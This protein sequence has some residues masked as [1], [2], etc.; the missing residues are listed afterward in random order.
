MLLLVVLMI[1]Y[2]AG[3]YVAGR[4]ARFNGPRQ[5]VA[6]W[7][8]G[9]A[10]TVVLAVAGAL[11]GAEYNVLSQLN[12]PRIPVDEGSLATG[13]LIAGRAVSAGQL[14]GNLAGHP[15]IDRFVTDRTGLTGRYDF[16]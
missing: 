5:G 13:G 3:G 16:R 10:V 8:I 2:Y 14:A 6:V 9:L 11:L 1:A 15:A 12:L 7:V 4:M